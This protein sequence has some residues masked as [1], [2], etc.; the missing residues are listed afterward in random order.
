MGNTGN[1]GDMG[2]TDVEID[3][4]RTWFQNQST[5][6]LE[7]DSKWNRYSDEKGDLGLKRSKIK[8]EAFLQKQLMEI[9]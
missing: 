1:T 2:N 7:S 6:E 9:K 3:E 4:K 5:N 8:E